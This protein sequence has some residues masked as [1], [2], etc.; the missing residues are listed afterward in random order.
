V[1]IDHRP[2]IAIS[3]LDRIHFIEGDA[4]E[5]PVLPWALNLLK[6]TG[7]CPVTLGGIQTEVMLVPVKG[8]FSIKGFV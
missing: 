5:P 6:E 1:I 2:Y 7:E 3:G 8:P 4:S